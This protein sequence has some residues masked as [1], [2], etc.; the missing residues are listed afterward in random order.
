MTVRSNRKDELE[1][2]LE[3]YDRFRDLLK[4]HNPLTSLV[5]MANKKGTNLQMPPGRPDFLKIDP[6]TKTEKKKIYGRLESI[7]NEPSKRTVIFKYSNELRGYIESSLLELDLGKR[8]NHPLA[9]VILELALVTDCNVG[10]LC[11]TILD[12]LDENKESV[13]AFFVLALFR[14][15]LTLTWFSAKSRKNAEEADDR[16]IRAYLRLISKKMRGNK[17]RKRSFLTIGDDK[18]ELPLTFDDNI[19]SILSRTLGSIFIIHG[20]I[21]LHFIEDHGYREKTLSQL[22]GITE[23]LFDAETLRTPR[24]RIYHTFLKMMIQ[25]AAGEDED[26]IRSYREALTGDTVSSLAHLALPDLYF[27]GRCA[28]IAGQQSLD[29]YPEDSVEYTS[30]AVTDMLLCGNMKETGLSLITYSE[31]ARSLGRNSIARN[32]AEFGM[33]IFESM[34]SDHYSA[35]AR[36]SFAW[37]LME[38]G[39]LRVSEKM[40]RKA[41][42]VFKKKSDVQG[43]TEALIGILAVYFRREKRR[44]ARRTLKRIVLSL[45]VK[46]YPKLFRLLKEEV[47][48]QEWLRDD[49]ELGQMFD[50]PRPVMVTRALVRKIIEFAKSS[51]PNE[52]GAAITCKGVHS[53][54]LSQVDGSGNPVFKVKEVL[55]DL[56]LLYSSSTNRNSVIFSKY[57]SAGSRISVDGFVHSHPSGAAIPSRADIRSFTMFVTNL[58]IGYPFTED[59]IAAYDRVGNRLEMEIVD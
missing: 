23:Q 6:H 53:G 7:M 41:G 42:K 35:S 31:S 4:G 12:T 28:A 18:N 45:P 30:E 20:S 40:F 57:D 36:T 47:M 25:S 50:K 38:D 8:Q 13:F 54:H 34:K 26:A 5:K 10:K 58:I 56:E 22:L 1:N 37:T 33:V 55:T 39:E 44:K 3:S 29:L 21:S 24:N 52:F 48:P 27:L 17:K 59:S 2:F 19:S 46:Q 49:R 14:Q 51:Y 16:L 9:L 43:Y 32:A 11:V 15:Y